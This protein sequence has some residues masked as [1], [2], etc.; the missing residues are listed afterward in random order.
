[1]ICLYFFDPFNILTKKVPISVHFKLSNL[2]IKGLFC[3]QISLKIL[4]SFSVRIKLLR[5]SKVSF[6]TI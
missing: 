6:E 3:E 4:K 5:S 2:I 1:M